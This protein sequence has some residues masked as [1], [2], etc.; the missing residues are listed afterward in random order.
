MAEEFINRL[1]ENRGSH[2]IK[3]DPH[4]NSA[5]L[6]EPGPVRLTAYE[7]CNEAKADILLHAQT[8]GADVENSMLKRVY[9][10][11]KGYLIEVSAKVFIDATGDG[12]L[13]YMSGAEYE[14]GE[15]VQPPTL[16]LTIGGVDKDKFFDYLDD[17]P[18][19]HVDDTRFLEK[20]PHMY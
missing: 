11:G 10:Y 5:A 14:I 12:D 20:S 2:G 17:H 3:F 8:I 16:M 18:E 19:D 13:G 9:A 4:H 6:N 15:E 1:V 7:M